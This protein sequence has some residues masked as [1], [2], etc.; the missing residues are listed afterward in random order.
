MRKPQ[1]FITLR[2]EK[3][4]VK[5]PFNRVI[6]PRIRVTTVTRRA[7]GLQ[8]VLKNGGLL[9][10]ITDRSHRVT[11]RKEAR[12]KVKAKVENLNVTKLRGVPLTERLAGETRT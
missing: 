3:D 11:R 12:V 7:T 5:E 8:T 10:V 4:P 2:V 1:R 9:R 6:G